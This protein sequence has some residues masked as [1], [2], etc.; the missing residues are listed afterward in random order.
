MWEGEGWAELKYCAQQWFF[1]LG[2]TLFCFVLLMAKLQNNRSRLSSTVFCIIAI[3]RPQ[4]N[5]TKW[6][7]QSMPGCYA[8]VLLSIFCFTLVV[9]LPTSKLCYIIY[10]YY[11]TVF[12]TYIY[13]KYHSYALLNIVKVDISF[14]QV[15][16]SVVFFRGIFL[17]F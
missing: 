10:C 5:V 8:F 6:C 17:F 9:L 16:S 15:L 12:K 3:W 11:F 4:V 7:N 1:L 14:A 2:G 13:L